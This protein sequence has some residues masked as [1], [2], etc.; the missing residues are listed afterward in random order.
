MFTSKIYFQKIFQVASFNNEHYGSEITLEPGDNI[1][2]A[3]KMALANCNEGI[4][5]NHP[6]TIHAYRLLR[7]NNDEL[8]VIQE[9]ER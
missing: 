4:E 1:C 6:T 7:Q 3:Y 2:D 8:P 9:K 5:M